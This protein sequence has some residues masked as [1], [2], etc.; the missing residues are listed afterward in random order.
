VTPG[1]FVQPAEVDFG[2]LHPGRPRAYA[3][4]TVAWTGPR[5]EQVRSGAGGEWWRQLHSES[6]ASGSIVFSLAAERRLGGPFGPQ[7]GQFAVTMDGTRVQVPLRATFLATAPD[8]AVPGQQGAGW[9]T[10][11]DWVRARFR[12]GNR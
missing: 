9:R 6:P 3:K 1:I 12:L 11:T 4:V 7:D 8:N 10:M 2:V 5:P